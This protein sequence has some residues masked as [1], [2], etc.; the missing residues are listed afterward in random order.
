MN[1]SNISV[2]LFRST[3]PNEPSSG[4]CTTSFRRL[5]ASSKYLVNSVVL[6][7]TCLI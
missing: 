2:I 4:K 3:F 6:L 7:S 5:S 1:E